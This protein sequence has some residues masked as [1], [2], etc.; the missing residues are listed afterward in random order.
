MIHSINKTFLQHVHYSYALTLVFSVPSRLEGGA[1][2]SAQVAGCA[3]APSGVPLAFKGL[4]VVTSAEL[5]QC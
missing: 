2:P 4:D 3:D 1:G 5:E